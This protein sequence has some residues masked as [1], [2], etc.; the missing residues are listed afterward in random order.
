[1]NSSFYNKSDN[2]VVEKRLDELLNSLYGLYGKEIDYSLD[3]LITFLEKLCNPHL[4]LPPVV[5][6]AGTNGKGSTL[7]TL[8]S[9]LEASDKKVHTYTSPHLVHPTERILLAGTPI[10]SEE[11]IE[12]L[13]ECLQINDSAP[14]TFFEI[15]TAAAFLAMSRTDADYTLLETGMGGRLDATNV[16]PNP[17]CTIITTISKDHSEFLG[18]DILDIAAEKAAIMKAGVPCIISH[19]TDQAIEAGILDVFQQQSQKLS[20]ASKLYHY[21]SDFKIETNSDGSKFIFE[22]NVIPLAPSNMIGPHQIYN[23]GSAIA[24]YR[25]IMGHNFNT[26]ILSPNHP[27]NALG[28]IYWPGRLQKITDGP[29]FDLIQPTQEL[30]IDGGHNDSAGKYLAQQAQIW[31]ESDKRPL[32]IILAM[33][34]RKDPLEFLEPLIPHTSQII[35]TEITNEPETYKCEEL[36]KKIQHLEHVNLSYTSNLK[37]SFACVKDPNSRILTTGSLYFMGNLLKLTLT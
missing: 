28:T 20:P 32:T 18:D 11:M 19:Q 21:G 26:N 7:A 17:V 31:N 9:L 15:F 3:R 4:K 34:N 10:S 16:I 24:A 30:W 2:P 6:I 37:E 12:V 35:C 33:V 22:E 5:H 23:I 8:R 14:I 36:Y 27:S 1:M 13:E 25:L 29:L